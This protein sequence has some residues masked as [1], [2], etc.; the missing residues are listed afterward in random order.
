M[1][2]TS[3]E[4][5]KIVSKRD[6][7]DINLL[8]SINDSIFKKTKKLIQEAPSLRIYLRHIGTFYYRDKKLDN[9]VRFP[10]GRTEEDIAFFNKVKAMYDEYYKDKYEFKIRKFGKESH[11]TYLL[12]KEQ[13]KLQKAKA[14]KSK[15]NL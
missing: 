13:K 11:E 7:I 4:I 15:D 3:K 12:D 6:N 14:D 9:Y 1:E 8:K 10:E 2:I 5:L